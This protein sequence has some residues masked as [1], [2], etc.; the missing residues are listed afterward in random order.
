MEFFRGSLDSGFEEE[1]NAIN[2]STSRSRSEK[3]GAFATYQ[4]FT[5]AT[6]LKPFSCI[7]VLFLSY[8]ISGYFVVSA[9]SNNYFEDAGAHALNYAADTAIS[10]TIK[11]CLSMIAPFILSMVSKKALFVITGF[12]GAIAFI[13]GNHIENYLF[14]KSKFCLLLIY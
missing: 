13:L 12:T 4:D 2:E 1:I 11:F 3:I 5:K 8:E 10:G 7:G 14:G 6:F 9:Y